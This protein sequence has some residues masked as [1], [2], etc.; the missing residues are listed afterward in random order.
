MRKRTDVSADALA[1][2]AASPGIKSSLIAREENLVDLPG[3]A[4]FKCGTNLVSLNE[5]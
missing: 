1:A 4:P 5:P 2:L 3:K